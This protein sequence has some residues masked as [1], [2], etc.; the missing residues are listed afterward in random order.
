MTAVEAI[1]CA[2]LMADH[3]TPWRGCHRCACT[4]NRCS[5]AQQVRK[6]REQRYRADL[7]PESRSVI[8][9]HFADL[10]VDA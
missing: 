1:C 3:A 9:S 6:L 2:H 4:S 8:G 7:L 5:A 10:A